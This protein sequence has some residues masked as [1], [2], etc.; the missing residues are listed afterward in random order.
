MFKEPSLSDVS[1][2]FELVKNSGALE[3]NTEYSYL[4]IAK[5][6]SQ[7]SA[8]CTENG[9]VVGYMSGYRLPENPA[10]LFVWQIA[11]DSNY[12]GRGIA[13]RLILDVLNR[14]QNREVS[15]VQATV[16]DSNNASA[17]LFKS[18]ATQ[19]ECDFSSAE[20]FKA[21]H[22]SE[23]HEAEPLLSVG[24]FQLNKEIK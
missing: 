13:K 24:P 1:T 21:E 16:A 12:R 5:H 8:I 14:P 6:F 19:L 15:Y 17:A 23:C 18:L 2:V 22:F 11:V 9:D 20:Y 10:V 4:L 3:V 7:T